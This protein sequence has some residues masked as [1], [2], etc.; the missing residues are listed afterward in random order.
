MTTD[1]LVHC[2]SK[3]GIGHYGNLEQNALL[4]LKAKPVEADERVSDVLG[5]PA[6]S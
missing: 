1:T 6:V 3:F 5:A 2:R 4:T